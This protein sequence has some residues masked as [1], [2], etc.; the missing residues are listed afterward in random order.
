MLIRAEEPL[1]KGDGIFFSFF[2]PDGA[3]VSGYGE[4]TRVEH[5]STSPDAF[6][7]GVKFTNI[8]PSVRSAIEA[9]VKR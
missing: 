8:A 2:L 9:V 3:H 6:L 4:I 1:V 5:K 7:Y